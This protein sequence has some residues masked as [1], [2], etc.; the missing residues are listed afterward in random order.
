MN[1]RFNFNKTLNLQHVIDAK[2][3][4]NPFKKLRFFVTNEDLLV[5]R[6]YKE[7]LEI[8]LTLAN[9]ALEILEN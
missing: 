9:K 8:E 5:L 3:A 1:R 6:A 2:F 4:L 7:H